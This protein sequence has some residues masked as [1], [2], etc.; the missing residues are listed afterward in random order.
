M[1]K[2]YCNC[3]CRCKIIYK[4]FFFVPAIGKRRFYPDAYKTYAPANFFVRMCNE[5]FGGEPPQKGGSPHESYQIPL[6]ILSSNIKKD[7]LSSL[8]N[9]SANFK[10]NSFSLYSL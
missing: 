10:S 6:I 7:Y 1:M 9:I 2:N 5:N 4:R 3:S 8:L